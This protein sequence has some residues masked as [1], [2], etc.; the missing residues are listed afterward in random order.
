MS[1]SYAYLNF[2]YNPL[3]FYLIVILFTWAAYLTAAFFSYN[4]NYAFYKYAFIYIAVF[5]PFTVAMFMINGSGNAELKKDFLY[6]LVNFKL[7][8]L[9]Y[10]LFILLVMPVTVVLAT[11]ASLLFGQP[12][13]QFAV[14]PGFSVTGGAAMGLLIGVIL[15]PTFEEL[16]WRGYGV[17]SL[18]KRGRTLFASTMMYAVLWAIW[19]VP[20][21]FINGYYHA[22]MLQA[23]VIYAVNFFVGIFPMAFLH[24]WMYYKNDR[25]IPAIILFHA[26]DNLSMSVLQIEQ[27][28]RCIVTVILIVISVVVLLK[29]RSLWLDKSWDT[30]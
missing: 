15:A 10:L 11:A 14:L 16:G 27:F 7:I 30:R 6:R 28:T 3:K 2:K 17:D 23:N 18:A 26:M 21:F 24:N 9:K 4:E 20:L 1:V 22:A 13:A 29:D 8:K 12:A 25:S 5:V 19:H